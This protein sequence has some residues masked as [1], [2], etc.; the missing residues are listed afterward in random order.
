VSLNI[1]KGRNRGQYRDLAETC[2]FN[3]ETK[4]VGQ[5]AAKKEISEAIVMIPFT[6]IKNHREGKDDAN[7]DKTKART[8]KEI[9]GENGKTSDVGTNGP[10]YFGVDRLAINTV[11]RQNG[12][13]VDF[14]SKVSY[15]DL[16]NILS[17]IENDNSI[18]KTMK[19]MS[20]YV[21]PPHLDW[22]YNR[23]ISPFVMY[24]FEFKH[25]LAGDELADIWQGVMPKS[26]MQAS[27]DTVEI[28]HALNDLEFFH[29]KKLP[30]DIQWKVF[31][32]KRRANYSYDSLVTGV[33]ERF[34]FKSRETEE[35]VYSYNWPYDY[36]SLV[37][38]VN[39]EAS[40]N[41][42]PIIPTATITTTT[43]QQAQTTRQQTLTVQE[44]SR[45]AEKDDDNIGSLGNLK[46][47]KV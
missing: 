18:L 43:G 26:A 41:V 46:N 38:L 19:A 9:I 1:I 40:L 5:I 7:F 10:Y 31:K 16:K 36:F 32:V 34:N 8:I 42:K 30:D 15:R 39:V 47:T 23:N 6:R 45:I 3:S 14:D 21:L 4:Y 25:E 2:G 27:L 17:N 11:L 37:E 35:L 28:E 24:V 44:A 20:N 13:S 29:G 33:E 12:V 22:L